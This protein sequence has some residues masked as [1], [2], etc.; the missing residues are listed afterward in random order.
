M[1]GDLQHQLTTTRGPQDFLGLVQVQARDLQLT[2][3]PWDLLASADRDLFQLA[4][5]LEDLLARW[6]AGG[7]GPPVTPR[8]QDLL[9]LLA[10]DGQC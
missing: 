6:S 1:L 3:G 2:P 10:G 5:R 8:P 7:Q 9:F 4:P